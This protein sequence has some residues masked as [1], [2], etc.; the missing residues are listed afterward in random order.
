MRA[1]VA[2]RRVIEIFVPARVDLHVRKRTAVHSF[3]M[4]SRLA[5]LLGL[6]ALAFTSTACTYKTQTQLREAPVDYSDYANYDRPFGVSPSDGLAR[7]ATAATTKTPVA[8]SQ[9]GSEGSADG[10]ADEVAV[11]DPSPATGAGFG[12]TAGNP[13]KTTQTTATEYEE[14]EATPG[15]ACYE[16]AVKAGILN[17]TCTLVSE[18]KY[19]LVGEKAR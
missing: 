2:S 11:R 19:V 10:F 14:V 12:F 4:T 18:R 1:P 3:T 9:I 15:T 6:A 5:G 8:D 7:P 16:A 17:G 13:R